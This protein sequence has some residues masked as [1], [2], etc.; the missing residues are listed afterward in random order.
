MLKSMLLLAGLAL[1]G[2]AP[3]AAERPAESHFF[4]ASFG[5]LP[6]E[7]QQARAEGKRGLFLMYAAEDCSPCIRMKKS[8]LSQARVQDYYRKHF[9]VLHIDFNGDLE[10][11]DLDRRTMRSKDFAQKVARIRGTP[12]FT[13]IDLDGRELLRHYGEIRD[14]G[15]FLL[16]G[17]YV[18]AGEYRNTPYD[19][20]RR[21]RLAAAPKR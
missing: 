15:Q 11:T 18:V 1:A 7:L 10:M 9:R 19:A 13:V 16:L 14:A 6:E 2:P 8:I 3:H 20:Y 4:Q 12:S 5:D 21:K 17:E